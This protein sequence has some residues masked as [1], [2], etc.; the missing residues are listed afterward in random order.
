MSESSRR[1]LGVSLLSLFMI[2]SGLL[3]VGA[4][5]FMIVQRDDDDLLKAVEASSSDVTTLG[6]VAIVSGVIATLVGLALRRG[7]GWART[8]VGV[9]A[10]ANVVFLVWSAIAHHYIHWYNVAWPTVIYALLAGYLFMDEDAKA[11]FS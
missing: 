10:V 3:Q 6:V 2:V 8:L 7:A 11:Y 9:I 4:G 1:P 5:I